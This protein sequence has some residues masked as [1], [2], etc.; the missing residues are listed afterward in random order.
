[1]LS[2]GY[3]IAGSPDTVRE[4]LAGTAAELGAG[5]FVGMFQFARL[6]H[7]D[8]MRSI[9]LFAKEVMPALRELAPQAAAL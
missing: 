4:S 9:E 8:T 3:V 1:L 2:E 7:A 5:N 6:P